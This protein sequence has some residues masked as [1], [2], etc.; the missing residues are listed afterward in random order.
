L[1]PFK[2]WPKAF[3]RGNA[4]VR[5]VMIHDEKFSKSLLPLLLPL[6]PPLPLSDWRE[7]CHIRVFLWW[8]VSVWPLPLSA[9]P[10]GVRP[11]PRP[12]PGSYPPN[13][14]VARLLPGVRLIPSA[15]AS[16]PLALL[17]LTT[18]S[19]WWIA[20]RTPHRLIALASYPIFIY[21]Y[22]FATQTRLQIA[23]ALID[24]IFIYHY[25]LAIQLASWC[26]SNY[27]V[28]C[29]GTRLDRP[30]QAHDTDLW[31]RLTQFSYITTHADLWVRLG[32]I[33]IDPIFIYHW[34]PSYSCPTGP[35]SR[36]KW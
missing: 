30:L 16:F 29:F 25:G 27:L 13:L 4:Y 26:K 24:P 3:R 8:A 17:T 36:I 22:G 23:L 28:K 5:S 10:S 33:L 20:T 14:I 21:H 35:A 19:E 12:L 34:S 15:L 18:I 31:V 7:H 2:P 1:C 9:T 6:L 32:L 11:W